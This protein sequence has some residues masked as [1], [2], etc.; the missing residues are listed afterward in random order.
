LVHILEKNVKGKKKDLHPEK[1]AWKVGGNECCWF[2]KLV[3]GWLGRGKVQSGRSSLQ[4][5][6]S[7]LYCNIQNALT[8]RDGL[9]EVKRPAG[10]E[11]CSIG[12][13]NIM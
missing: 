11:T 1:G 12:W 8:R 4:I 5:R 2:T 9:L 10:G 13:V 3:T 6:K 7:A